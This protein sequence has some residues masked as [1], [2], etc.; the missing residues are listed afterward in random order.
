M[1][2]EPLVLLRPLFRTYELPTGRRIV[3]VRVFAAAARRL[4]L[5]EL[6]TAAAAAEQAELITLQL[7]QAWRQRAATSGAPNPRVQQL[8]F[9]LD[10]LIGGLF[11]LGTTIQRLKGPGHPHG[12]AAAAM[13]AD[14]FPDGLA[15][16]TNI[17][18]PEEI[19]RATVIA[20]SLGRY[21]EFLTAY[22]AGDLQARVRGVLTALDEA[23]QGHRPT[24]GPSWDDVKTGRREGNERLLALVAKAIAA[25]P[26]SSATDVAGRTE[27]LG[28]FLQQ[29][30]AVGERRRLGPDEVDDVDPDATDAATAALPPEP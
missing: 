14:L 21:A 11:D 15:A 29:N 6:A 16:V 9:E 2:Y 1:A 26:S 24:S 7:E 30:A 23:Y 13:L 18:V 4:G 3:S 17:P 10:D 27:L 22:Q 25:F 19:G 5:P 28:G 20:G 8:D 12:V